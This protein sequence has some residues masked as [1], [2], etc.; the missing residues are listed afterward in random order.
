ME[1]LYNKRLLAK[2]KNLMKSKGFKC[3]CR[4]RSVLYFEEIGLVLAIGNNGNFIAYNK[5]NVNKIDVSFMA[6][7]IGQ[8]LIK[9]SRFGILNPYLIDLILSDKQY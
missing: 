4:N 9:L 5:M 1:N 7:S 3:N 8:I 2:F 6:N